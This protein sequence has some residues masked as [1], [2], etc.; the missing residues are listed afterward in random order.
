MGMCPQDDLISITIVTFI[1]TKTCPNMTNDWWSFKIAHVWC[2]WLSAGFVGWH[3]IYM[4]RESS[5]KSHPG[6]KYDMMARILTNGWEFWV[7]CIRNSASFFPWRY[8]TWNT[9]ALS[10]AFMIWR[11]VNKLGI[12]QR[13]D[14]QKMTIGETGWWNITFCAHGIRMKGISLTPGF[15]KLNI[16]RM[17]DTTF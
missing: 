10:Q 15:I 12:K 2:K 17:N 4:M 9:V 16:I 14:V 3:W 6:W 13:E 5:I 1:D 8:A 7:I 11:T